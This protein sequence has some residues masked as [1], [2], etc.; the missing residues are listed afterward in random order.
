MDF[1]I[2]QLE[3]F[4]VLAEKLNFGRAAT[5]LN[6]AQPTLSFQI[7][8]L[9]TTFGVDLFDR[10]QRQVRLTAAGQRLREHA[11][12][13]IEHTYEAMHSVDKRVSQRLTI[14]CGPVGQFTVLPDVLRELRTNHRDLE[15]TI[16]TLSPEEM[17]QATTN[18]TIDVFLMTP[19]WQLPGMQFLGLRADIL[20]AVLPESHPAARRGWITL[21]EFC[22]NRVF[23]AAAKDCQKHRGF[24][25]RLFEKYGLTAELLEASSS[26]G[27]QVA[28]VAAGL[29]VAL[30]AGS[31]SRANF[32]GVKIVPFDRVIHNMEL[33]MMWHKGNESHWLVIFREVVKEVIRLQNESALSAC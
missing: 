32:P 5:A 30:A 14:S 22:Q 19:D 23:V 2:R 4:L 3:Y 16:L 8:A 9:E 25:T 17:K 24:V 6:I 31:I 7:K 12:L 28:M 10:T 33:G 1:R 27:I 13:I 11:K 29:G 21:E 20:S 15:L 18:G 26:N